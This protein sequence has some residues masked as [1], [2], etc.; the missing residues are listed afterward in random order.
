MTRP[1]SHREQVFPQRCGNCFFAHAPYFK[2]DH[3]LC[4]HGDAIEINRWHYTDSKEVNTDV[5]LDGEDVGLM[6]GD[7]YSEVWG[8]RVV[9]PI[10]EVCDEWKAEASP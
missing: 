3:L 6:E 1:A 7:A 5:R 10:T 8:G 2:R 4:F 9:D